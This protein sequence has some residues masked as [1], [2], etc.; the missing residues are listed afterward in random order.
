MARHPETDVDAASDC[1]DAVRSNREWHR[2]VGTHLN[3]LCTAKI[4]I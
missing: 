1:V 4:A 3:V 2:V